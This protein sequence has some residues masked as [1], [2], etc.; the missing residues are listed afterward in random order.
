MG[1]KTQKKY[2]T[3][4]LIIRDALRKVLEKKHAKDKK[5]RIID[6]L[7]VHHGSVRIDIA[8]INGIMHGYEI[9][10]DCDTLMR[11]PQ[12][13]EA[14]CAIFDQV[15]IVVGTKHFIN[16]FRMIPDWW[17]I[18]T[19]HVN[20]D[21]SI[22]FNQ[23]RKP[24]DNPG[25]DNMAIARL[26]W[27]QEALDKLE[28]LGMAKGIRSK[29]RELVYERLAKSIHLKPL[30]RYVRSVLHSSRQ[31]WRSVGQPA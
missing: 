3:N 12:Q 30:K 17:G 26:L 29:P 4:D 13:M 9:K 20:E 31:N 24:T 14:Y 2:S 25:Q 18:E 11:L 21:G 19:A 23:I 10:S 16:V 5:L 28:A 15:T 1:T 22:F 8:V 27:R 7:G 6:E